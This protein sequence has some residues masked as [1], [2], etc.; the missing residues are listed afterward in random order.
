MLK[1]LSLISCSAKQREIVI[2]E[3]FRENGK[4]LN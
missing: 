4:G 2:I 1:A 3:I